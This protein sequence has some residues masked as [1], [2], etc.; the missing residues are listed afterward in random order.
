MGQA[1]RFPGG[2]LTALFLDDV[3]GHRPALGGAGRFQSDPRWHDLLAFSE[4]FHGDA[5]DAG[6]GLGASY[7]T[8]WPALV[9]DLILETRRSQ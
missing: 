9:L 6:A 1:R 7:Q 2:R 8:G 4:Y 5:G 3:A